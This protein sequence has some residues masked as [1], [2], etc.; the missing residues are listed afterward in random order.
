M[1]RSRSVHECKQHCGVPSLHGGHGRDVQIRNG[2]V[3][4]RS[5]RYHS[6][7]DGG[8]AFYRLARHADA[9]VQAVQ[10]R[11]ARGHGKSLDDRDARRLR[12]CFDFFFFFVVHSGDGGDPSGSDGV[13]R[14]TT[15]ARRGESRGM[16]GEMVARPRLF[17]WNECIQ[18]S[19]RGTGDGAPVLDPC[20]Q[21][22][23]SLSRSRGAQGRCALR[24]D[25]ARRG[26][27]QLSQ[28]GSC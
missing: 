21:R 12:L 23:S 10:E 1:P 11:D 13:R 8:R 20:T 24:A 16:H 18:L 26:A 4:A 28:T 9:A 3:S 17:R 22:V 14:R 2:L 6:N 25:Q 27:L 19:V 7:A 5:V 15:A